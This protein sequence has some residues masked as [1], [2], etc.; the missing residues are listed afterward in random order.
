MTKLNDELNQR[1]T[2]YHP[3][4]LEDF[5]IRLDPPTLLEISSF[6]DGLERGFKSGEKNAGILRWEIDYDGKPYAFIPKQ[7]AYELLESGECDELNWHVSRKFEPPVMITQ[8]SMLP[9]KR[10][11]AVR[12]TITK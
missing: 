4:K 8:Y 7:W 10:R 3:T 1:S 12:S 11:K 6:K 2:P 5:L 9:A